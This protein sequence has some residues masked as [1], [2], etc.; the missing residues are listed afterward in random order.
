MGGKKRLTLSQAEKALAREA[1][2]KEGKKE[3]K[4]KEPARVEKKVASVIPP[5]LKDDKIIKEIQ[6]MKALTP[7]SVASRFN[8]RLSV[9]KDFL[10]ELHR[11]G[12]IT[13]VS[14]GRYI[15]IY[16]PA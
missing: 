12:V 7:Y 5:S 16:K 11:Q 9:A 13:Y 2:K 14:G 6:R 10:E 3:T 1:Q 15:K 4:T 8:L